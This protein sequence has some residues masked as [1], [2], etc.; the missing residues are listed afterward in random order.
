MAHW[1]GP[2]I[3]LAHASRRGT[4]GQVAARTV[5]AMKRLLRCEPAAMLAAVAPSIGACCYQVGEEVLEEARAALPRAERFFT[6]R[7]DALY[8]DLWAANVAHVVEAGVPRE[9]IELSGICTCCH[10]DEFFS[11]RASGGKTGRFALLLGL[12]A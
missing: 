11:Y 8:L 2:A 3:G 10:A 6:R 7:N 4:L 9:Q 5:R 12:E 1:Q